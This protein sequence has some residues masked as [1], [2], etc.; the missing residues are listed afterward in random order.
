MVDSPFF[1]FQKKIEK[2]QAHNDLIKKTAPKDINLEAL[3][4]ALDLSVELINDLFIEYNKSQ[5]K[6]A[7]L[8]TQLHEAVSKYNEKY[9]EDKELWTKLSRIFEE[10]KT[11]AEIASQDSKGE[12]T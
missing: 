5:E 8:E 12:R 6:A 11:I 2:L 3:K 4:I 1:T 7:S 10:A 9:R